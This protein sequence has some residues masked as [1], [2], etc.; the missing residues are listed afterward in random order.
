MLTFFFFLVFSCYFFSVKYQALFR[1]THSTMWYNQVCDT[2]STRTRSTIIW[3]E[4]RYSRACLDIIISPSPTKQNNRSTVFRSNSITN[5]A[6]V[7]IVAQSFA[8]TTI[9]RPVDRSNG[10]YAIYNLFSDDI[11]PRK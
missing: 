1:G 8:H 3:N 9:P 11:Y 10:I 2:S 5:P 7:E 4:K 6:R